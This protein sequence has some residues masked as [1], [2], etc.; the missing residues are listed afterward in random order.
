MLAALGGG[1]QPDEYVTQLLGKWTE[2]DKA[3]L[4]ELMPLVY[5]EL[6]SLAKRYLKSERAD[7]TLQPTALV[8]EVYLRLVGQRTASF[9]SRAQFFGMAAKL[10]RNILVDHARKRRTTKRGGEPYRISISTADR[11]GRKPDLDLVALDDALIRLSALNQ[12]HSDTIELRFFGG[13]TIEETAEAMG[14]S[15]ATVERDWSF[16]RAWLRREMSA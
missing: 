15:H 11:I 9:R 2:G 4:D 6:R 5:N 3:A 16:A 14:V 7:H 13:L 1:M 12:Q 8:N 10:M